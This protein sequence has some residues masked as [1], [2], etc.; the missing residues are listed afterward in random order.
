[1]KVVSSL[2]KNQF[3]KNVIKYYQIFG[4]KLK[5]L[6]NNSIKIIG[7]IVSIAIAIG[8]NDQLTF[9]SMINDIPAEFAKGIVK[10]LY[11]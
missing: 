6:Q 4:F 7:L 3:I 11:A 2:D 9:N 1:M 5:I 8:V 10:F